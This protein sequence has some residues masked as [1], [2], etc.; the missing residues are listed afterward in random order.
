MRIKDTGAF[1]TVTASAQDVEKFAKTWPCS[2]FNSGDRAAFEFHKRTGDLIG[3]RVNNKPPYDVSDS[4]LLALSQ[5][6]QAFAVRSGK[7]V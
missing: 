3:V 7:T 2:G 1:Y 5:D 6:C 4:A